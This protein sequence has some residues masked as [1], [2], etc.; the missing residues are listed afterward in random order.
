M[1]FLLPS[2]R[3]ASHSS[4]RR[5]CGCR[6]RGSRRNRSRRRARARSIDNDIDD[7]AHVLVGGAAHLAA[8]NALRLRGVENGHRGLGARPVCLR[9]GC[10]GTRRTAVRCGLHARPPAA[11]SESCE[12]ADVAVKSSAM[13]SACNRDVPTGTA[14]MRMGQRGAWQPRVPS[15]DAATSVGTNSG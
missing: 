7:A 9:D 12:Q 11:A 10:P 8:E 6:R 1:S 3:S 5:S 13:I 14:G 2:G 15:P 4:R